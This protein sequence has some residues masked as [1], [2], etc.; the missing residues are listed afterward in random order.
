MQWRLA[1]QGFFLQLDR[2][3]ASIQQQH[4]V[5]IEAVFADEL[6]LGEAEPRAWQ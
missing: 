3:E 5:S 6:M 2:N 1:E 4:N